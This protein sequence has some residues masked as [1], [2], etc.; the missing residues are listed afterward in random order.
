MSCGTRRRKL[1]KKSQQQTNEAIRLYVG[2]NEVMSSAFLLNKI[3]STTK[4]QA[5]TK[6]LYL[7]NKKNAEKWQSVT[8]KYLNSFFFFYLKLRLQLIENE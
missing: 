5:T 2:K 4:L 6:N 3:N 7:Y 8:N 1:N